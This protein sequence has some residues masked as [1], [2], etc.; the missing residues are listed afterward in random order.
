MYNFYLKGQ[1][2]LLFF[3]KPPKFSNVMEWDCS[4]SMHPILSSHLSTEIILEGLACSCLD[5]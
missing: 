1:S 5:R 2:I 3:R 4:V